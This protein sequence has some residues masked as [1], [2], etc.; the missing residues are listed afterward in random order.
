MNLI[1][2]KKK[3]G[4][5]F[6]TDKN[7]AEKIVSYLAYKKAKT[8]IEVGPGK[9]ILS[10]MIMNLTVENKKFVEIDLD[11]VEYLKKQYPKI[12]NDIINEDF[13]KIDITKFKNPLS[14]IGNFPYNISSQILF[15]SSESSLKLL[16]SILSIII[17]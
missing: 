12:K 6:L 5:N 15:N 8:I 11:C 17:C 1:K 16:L 7:I 2:S 4:Q 13:L 3:F 10:K 14:I 9:G